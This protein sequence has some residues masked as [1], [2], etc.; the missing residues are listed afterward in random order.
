MRLIAIKI[1][2]KIK[3][4][5]IGQKTEKGIIADRLFQVSDQVSRIH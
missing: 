5:S 1:G 4:I 2:N 3:I